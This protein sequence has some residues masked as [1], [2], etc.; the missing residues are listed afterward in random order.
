MALTGV[1]KYSR[2]NIFIYT[3]FD[4]SQNLFMFKIKQQ[5]YF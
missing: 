5:R 3:Y 2:N 4:Y 1:V